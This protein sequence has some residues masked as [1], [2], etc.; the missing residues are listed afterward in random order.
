MTRE[1]TVACML[2]E[3]VGVSQKVLFTW[4]FCHDAL[5]LICLK[6]DRK[7]IPL[8]DKRQLCYW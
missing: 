6:Q 4:R 5:R 7:F 3:L 1:F 2:H 8:P